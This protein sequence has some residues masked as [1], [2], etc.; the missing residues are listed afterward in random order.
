MNELPLGIYFQKKTFKFETKKVF[1]PQSLK[2]NFFPFCKEKEEEEILEYE[3]DP[4]DEQGEKIEKLSPTKVFKNKSN[5]QDLVHKR[6]LFQNL[7]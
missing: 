5:H 1:L 7:C 3:E 4:E 6:N 2:D